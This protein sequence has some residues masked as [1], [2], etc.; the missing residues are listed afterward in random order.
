MI[1]LRRTLK[2]IDRESDRAIEANMARRKS[3]AAAPDQNRDSSSDTQSSRALS[4]QA[5]GYTVLARRYRPQQFADLV[6]QEPVVQALVNALN[7]N[8]VAHA[9]LFTG[10][11]GVGK[12]STARILAKALNCVK[13]PTAT[14][15]DQCE[16]CCSIASG[17]DVDVLEIDGASNRGIDEVREIRQNVQYRP[18]RSRFKIYIV[19]EVHM[20]TAPAFNALLKTL[21]EPPPHVKFIFATT[22]VQRIPVTI[23]S[24]CQRFDFA[25]IG[26]AQ[27]VDRLRDMVSQEGMQADDEALELVARRAGGSMRDA[28]SLLDQLLA[29]GG[30]RLTADQVHQM[31][32]TAH[33]DWV[34]ALAAA[35][36]DHDAK[37]ALELLTKADAEGLQVGELVDQLI[38]YW[39]DLMVIK[40]AGEQARN[41]SLPP[42]HRP[43][44]VQQA[45]A[46]SLDTILAGL[47]VLDTTKA[48]LRVSSHPRVL[49]EMALVRL[50]RLDDLL[51]LTQLAQWLDQGPGAGSVRTETSKSTV[52]AARSEGAATARQGVPAGSS[53]ALKKKLI[54]GEDGY[55]PPVRLP[56]S[57][58]SLPALWQEILQRT[59]PLLARELSRAEMPAIS[60]PNTLVLRFPIDYNAAREYIEQPGTV[61]R[62]ESLLE[63]LTGAKC[64][65]RVDGAPATAVGNPSATANRKEETQSPYR[66]KQ[67]EAL[68]EPL[69]RKAMERMGAQI[70]EV[71]DGFG[72]VP[73]A[74][75]ESASSSET[76]DD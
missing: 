26:T 16:I 5:D 67:A 38:D 27:I 12:T 48:R 21:E 63:A 69:V 71:D 31:L 19:D 4:R 34:L 44:L 60:G 56:L 73:E 72:A 23:L 40:A 45:E 35:V 22:E 76:E 7:S 24:R 46:L 11:R 32:G 65:L 52:S 36:L 70:L 39:R 62:I 43:T 49:I 20:L 3:P 75:A 41:I 25:G 13:G 61:A 33:D 64:N 15:C 74:P 50:G 58:E 59:G 47:E 17:E 6:G 8:R 30:D 14:P 37:Q 55:R 66:R 42:R 18:G 57:V 2:A 28:Q 29:F 9:Y 68:K 53:E 51:S 10:A 1:Q 54:P